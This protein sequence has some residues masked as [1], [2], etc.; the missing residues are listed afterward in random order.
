MDL[1]NLI[2]FIQNT[3]WITLVFKIAASLIAI[4]FVV[5]SLIFHQQLKKMDKTAS[6]YMADLFEESKKS[7][8]LFVVFS[9]LQIFL[10]FS[11]LVFSLILL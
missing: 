11:L 1:S 2:Q 6:A 9:Y 5:Y 10:S 3:N 8:S 7:T 4:G